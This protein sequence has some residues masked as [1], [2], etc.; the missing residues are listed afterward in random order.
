MNL[1]ETID[2]TSERMTEDDKNE[3][4]GLLNS[5]SKDKVA[6]ELIPIVK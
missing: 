1:Y 4:L 2:S 5:M 6:F 3:I